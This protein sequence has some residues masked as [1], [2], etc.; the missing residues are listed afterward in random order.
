[1][2]TCAHTAYGFNPNARLGYTMT[3]DERIWGCTEW[4]FGYQGP[5]YTGVSRVAQLPTLTAFAWPAR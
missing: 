4:G 5:M 1:M 3:E 2:Y